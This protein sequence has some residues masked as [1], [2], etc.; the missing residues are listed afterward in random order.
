MNDR[1]KRSKILRSLGNVESELLIRNNQQVFGHARYISEETQAHVE[2]TTNSYDFGDG[3]E[4]ITLKELIF[5]GMISQRYII[6]IFIQLV[7][8]VEGLYLIG[9]SLGEISLEDLAVTKDYEIKLTKYDNIKKS[10]CYKVN[11][12]NWL[13]MP[14]ECYRGQTYNTWQTDIFSLACLLFNMISPGLYPFQNQ[15]T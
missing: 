10:G 3:R 12:T 14:P 15:A 4:H 2:I 5:S 9:K 11:E 13:N 7:E 6:L 1:R 8:L